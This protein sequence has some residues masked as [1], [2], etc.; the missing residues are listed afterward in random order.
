VPDRD[1]DDW[2]LWS[3]PGPR[4]DLEREAAAPLIGSTGERTEGERGNGA[5]EEEGGGGGKGMVKVGRSD[6]PMLESTLC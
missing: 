4:C 5:E 6:V 3:V 2:F 1:D